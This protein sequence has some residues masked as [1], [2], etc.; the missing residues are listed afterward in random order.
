MIHLNFIE[1]IQ[2]FANFLHEHEI[3]CYLLSNNSE[4]YL[5]YQPDSVSRVCVLTGFVSSNVKIIIGFLDGSQKK[6]KIFC[7]T[8]SRYELAANNYFSNL[9]E[10]DIEFELIIGNSKVSLAKCVG[11]NK[12]LYD[13]RIFSELEIKNFSK[14]F[15]DFELI[16]DQSLVSL[17]NEFFKINFP[18]CNSGVN[19]GSAFVYEQRYSGQNTQQKIQQ[20][21]TKLSEKK[22]D[23]QYYFFSDPCSI[24]WLLNIRGVDL[25]YVPIFIC[26]ALLDI[27]NYSIQIFCERPDLLDVQMINYEQIAILP[28]NQLEIILKNLNNKKCLVSMSSNV[29]MFYAQFK[30]DQCDYIEDFCTYLSSIKNETEISNSMQGHLADGVALTKFW[31]WL[32]NLKDEDRNSL[33][34]YT[35]GQKIIH[36][37][38]EISVELG[39]EF[40]ES[41]FESICG[42]EQ[43]SALIHYHT[44][45]E[46]SYKIGTKNGLLLLDCGSHYLGCTTDITRVFAI[47]N[48]KPTYEQKF[49]Y[50]LCL[51]A[52]LAI[53]LNRF[54]L[55]STLMNQLSIIV[56][57]K[58]YKYS[59]ICPHG[60]GHGVSNMLSVHEKPYSISNSCILALVENLILSNEPGLY[61][62]GKFGIRIENLIL[63]KI[64][65]DN[66]NFIEFVN[67]TQ[68]FYDPLL[69]DFTQL[70][71]EEKV[72]IKQ[73]HA[74]VFEKIKP[75]LDADEIEWLFSKVMNFTQF[76]PLYSLE[77]LQ[78]DLVR[79][80]IDLHYFEKIGSTSDYAMQM[81]ENCKK[82]FT[83]LNVC[84]VMSQMQTKGRGKTGNIW[85]SKLGGIYLSVIYPLPNNW[86]CRL[87]VQFSLLTGLVLLKLIKKHLSYGHDHDKLSL[88]WPNDVLFEGKKLAGIL[89]EIFM[90]HLI[91]GIGVNFNNKTMLKNCEYLAQ[92]I[93]VDLYKFAYDLIEQMTILI[94][95][96]LDKRSNFENFLEEINNVLFREKSDKYHQPL[97]VLHDGTL[98]SINLETAELINF[99]NIFEFY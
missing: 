60:I 93:N 17:I 65:S 42:F 19:L 29:N 7:I 63:S 1:N 3:G 20:I 99:S 51:K 81:I 48:H 82:N 13:Q 12:I 2:K 64:C 14:N 84:A 16:F 53:M 68:F 34:E 38:K 44:S 37:K 15:T 96:L 55:K 24:N 77:Q 31:Y 10:H 94:Q 95:D 26:H 98:Q 97:R 59:Q 79:K 67:L 78:S 90:N 25:K 8:D 49:F 21:C 41:S 27:K 70:D 69:I 11:W 80:N 22:T 87:G 76:K 50:T 43:N 46:N 32:D 35:I 83:I 36:F 58:L 40:I 33:T 4:Y 74:G 91:M 54:P 56:A 30:Y 85:C 6:I 28:I 89:P 39:L 61:F 23:L 88:K 62:A 52:H 72:F 86:L 5:E 57:Q 9:F 45:L 47:N 92:Y 66:E 18:L 71:L 75:Y 73:Y